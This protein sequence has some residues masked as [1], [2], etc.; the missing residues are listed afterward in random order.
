MIRKIRGSSNKEVDGLTE[1]MVVAQGIIFL[2]AGFET[3]S[4]T[5]S[6]LLYSLAKNPLIQE[7]CYGEISG[8]L[9][10]DEKEIDY[11]TV[12]EMPY[13]EACIQETLRLYPIVLRNQRACVKDSN[14]NGMLIKKGTQVIVPTWAMHR[15]PELFGDDASDFIPERFLEDGGEKMAEHVSNHTF[16]A[17][18]GGPRICIGMRFAMVEMKIAISKLLKNF[19]IGDEPGVTKLDIQKGGLFLLTY[20]DMKVKIKRR[21]TSFKE[22]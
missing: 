18:G 8:V 17:F 19:T 14:I 13:L 5:M 9:S 7:K 16:H 4:S 1:D 10:D 6:L 12:N 22:E 3:T 20:P 21:A 2:A 15:N 11:E